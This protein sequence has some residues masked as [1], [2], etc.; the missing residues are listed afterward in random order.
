MASFHTVEANDIYS[1][2]GSVKHYVGVTC[3]YLLY[4]NINCG[5][6]QLLMCVDYLSGAIAILVLSV[7][8]CTKFLT[9][10]ECMNVI[11]H[12]LFCLLET[13]VQ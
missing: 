11:V 5:S 3:K 9:L 1:I 10:V 8:R 2:L 6:E 4:V 12:F 7:L 13:A